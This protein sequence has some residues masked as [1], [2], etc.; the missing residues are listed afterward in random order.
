M[1]TIT[2]EPTYYNRKI[3][4]INGRKYY[5]LN[6]IDTIEKT[7]AGKW[8]GT[9]NQVPFMICGGTE[10]GGYKHEWFAQYNDERVF[11]CNNAVAALTFIAQT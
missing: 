7:G 10:A 6:R 11:R 8:E 4:I 1:T 9:M 3:F 2:T 5:D